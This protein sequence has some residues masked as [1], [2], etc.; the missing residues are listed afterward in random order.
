[1]KEKRFRLGLLS[2]LLVAVVAV[3]TMA[4]TAMAAPNDVTVTLDGKQ[5]DFDQP[6]IIQEGRTLVPM[7]A[8]FEAMGASVDWDGPSQTVTS[9]RGDVTIVMTV[10][11][12]TMTRNGQVITLEVPAQILNGRTLV[13]IRAISDAFG[14]EC[15]WDGD[16]RT[17]TITSD[18][19]TTPGEPFSALAYERYPG[20]ENAPEWLVAID[21]VPSDSPEAD[22]YFNGDA[23]GAFT[24]YVTKPDDMTNAQ[25]EELKAY[26]QKHPRPTALW[27]TDGNWHFERTAFASSYQ[28][29]YLYNQENTDLTSNFVQDYYDDLI[30]YLYKNMKNGN[31]NGGNLINLIP[32]I[33]GGLVY[34][35]YPGDENAPDWMVHFV[36]EVDFAFYEDVYVTKPS[37]MNQEVWEEIKT[38][39]RNEERPESFPTKVPSA[40]DVAPSLLDRTNF[41]QEAFDEPL[42]ELYNI[43]MNRKNGLPDNAV[44][45]PEPGRN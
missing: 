43:M 18:A 1:M 4:P 20:D 6:P 38:F 33:P 9:T 10:G 14:G 39:F 13:P 7:R 34:E 28:P 37:D 3:F 12:T 22:A 24:V 19:G 21:V 41:V 15:V 44:I 16:A 35:P 42:H 5:V 36:A 25:W 26:Y 32:S 23:S 29:V 40:V 8:I 2:L 11:S 17:V 30:N 27:P 31:P 45:F